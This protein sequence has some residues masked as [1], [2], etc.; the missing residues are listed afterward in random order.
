MH[1]PILILHAMKYPDAKAA[2]DKECEKIEKLPAWQRPKPTAKKKKVIERAQKEERTI[3]FATLVVLCHLKK[4]E[5]EQKFRTVEGFCCSPRCCSEDDSRSYTVFTEQRSSA[6]QIT[7][8][9]NLDVV[10]KLLGCAGQASDAVSAYTQVEV[11]DDPTPLKLP[12]SECP[13]NWIRLPRYKWPRGWQNVEEPVVPFERNL[14]GQS[15]AGLIWVRKFEKIVLQN[16]WEKAPTWECLSIANKD[17]VHRNTW[18]TSNLG[19]E[20]EFGAN[21]ENVGLIWR[22]QQRFLIKNTCVVLHWNANR[23]TV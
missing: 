18:T 5:L 6:S 12:K 4:S 16:G 3:H 8:A 23:T 14:C 7:A 20:A 2:V 17:F 11:E 13:D 9:K 21:V 22:N 19:E 10:V 1:K 15:L